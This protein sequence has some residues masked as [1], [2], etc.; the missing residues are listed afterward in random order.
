MRALCCNQY[1]AKWS[2]TCDYKASSLQCVCVCVCVCACTRLV[3]QF[4]PTLCDPM[5]YSLPDSSVHGILQA[6][7]VEWVAIFSPRG[8]SWLRYQI[9]ISCTAG[10]FFYIWA[11]REAPNCNIT[12][13]IA[14]L[15]IIKMLKVLGLTWNYDWLIALYN[16]VQMPS[17]YWRGETRNKTHMMFLWFCNS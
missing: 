15:V 13:Q 2:I 5:D 1:F 17:N 16:F 7:K 11:T 8:Y 10:R 9:W 4:C 6:I 14:G 3:A 12:H